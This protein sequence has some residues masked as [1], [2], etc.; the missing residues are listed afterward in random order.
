MRHDAFGLGNDTGLIA[1]VLFLL[2]VVISNDV[3]LRR[4]GTQKWKSLQRWTY[5]VVTL[6][7]LHG[8]AYQQVEKRSLAYKSVLWSTITLI[9][10]LQLSG[11]WRTKRIYHSWFREKCPEPQP[12][13]G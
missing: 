8:V 3:S 5:V 2:L 7:F 6:T 13:I 4:L 1:A 10:A 11:W 9:T 12:P